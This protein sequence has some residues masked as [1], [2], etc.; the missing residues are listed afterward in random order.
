[1]SP[2][3]TKLPVSRLAS[4]WFH[5]GAK[6]A[7]GRLEPVTAEGGEEVDNLESQT[8]VCQP[9]MQPKG[10]TLTIPNL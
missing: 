9:G 3:G 7:L 2:A 4:A 8:D 10:S 6:E 1:M 5:N